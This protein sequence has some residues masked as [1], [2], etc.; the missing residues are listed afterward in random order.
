MGKNWS[1]ANRWEAE[2]ITIDEAERHYPPLTGDKRSAHVPHILKPFGFQSPQWEALKGQMQPG[3]ELWSFTS[4]K[5]D[6]S[7]LM[8]RAGIALV[9]DGVMIASIITR[10]N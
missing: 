10:M 3:D 1:P 7:R 5:E 8:G 4:P 2:R 6:W 9:R